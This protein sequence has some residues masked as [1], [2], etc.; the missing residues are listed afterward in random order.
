MIELDKD[1]ERY[2]SIPTAVR[3]MLLAFGS[4][5]YMPTCVVL[6]RDGYMR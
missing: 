5:A 4:G 2:G 6:W 1:T 3:I